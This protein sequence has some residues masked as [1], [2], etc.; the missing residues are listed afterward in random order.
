MFGEYIG[1]N[2]SLEF[3]G[4]YLDRGYSV[5]LFPEGL[6]T[7]GG[8]MLPFKKGIGFLALNMKVPIVPI[9]IIDF[10]KVLPRKKYLPKFHKT[11]IKIGKPFY[12]DYFKDMSYDK[13]SKVIE[14][15]VID[16]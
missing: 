14:K 7:R 11:Y 12:P 2:K 5:L 8:K 10:H 15:S 3:T 4:E 16:L 13:A 6:M 9:K 1:T